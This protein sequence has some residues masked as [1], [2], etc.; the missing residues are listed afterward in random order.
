[1]RRRGAGHEMLVELE[2]AGLRD[3]FVFEELAEC[4]L[5]LGRGDEARKHFAAAYVELSQDP[6][7]TRDEPQR[8]ARLKELSQP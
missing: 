3:G 5:L 1:M 4:C 7:L 2:A 6:W 8:L